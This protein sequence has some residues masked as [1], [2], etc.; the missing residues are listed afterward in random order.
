MQSAILVRM[1]KEKKNKQTKK[2]KQKQNH[3]N[4][5]MFPISYIKRCLVP[6]PPMYFFCLAV[7]TKQ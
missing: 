1:S 3:T 4:V 7:E 6:S 5:N 2:S